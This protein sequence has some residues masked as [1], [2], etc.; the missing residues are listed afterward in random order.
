MKVVADDGRFLKSVI[1][2]QSV[3]RGRRVRRLMIG[4]VRRELREIASGLGDPSVISYSR[5][6]ALCLPSFAVKSPSPP[7]RRV[8]HKEPVVVDNV[9]VDQEQRLMRDLAWAQRA[10][11]DRCIHL[12]GL[13]D[14]L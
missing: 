10:V 12:R 8:S 7:P 13:L 2:V 6:H 3:Y 1:T 14:T 11:I 9:D 5:V 4:G